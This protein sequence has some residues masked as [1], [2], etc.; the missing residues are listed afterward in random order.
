MTSRQSMI[1]VVAARVAE[2]AARIFDTIGTTDQF[3]HEIVTA[4]QCDECIRR[5]AADLMALA[6]MTDAEYEAR[7]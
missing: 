1:N 7:G 4:E 2:Q 6:N 3:F 5:G